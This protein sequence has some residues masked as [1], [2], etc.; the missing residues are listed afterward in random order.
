MNTVAPR[1]LTLHRLERALKERVRYRFVQPTVWID[2]QGYRVESPCCSRN[3]DPSGGTIAIA[4]L[5][6]PAA[7]AQATA[8]GWTLCARDHHNE[9]WVQHSH[10]DQIEPLL[11]LL[12]VD[13]E[14]RFWP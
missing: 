13:S 6:P 3:V 9:A 14:R 2:E 12:C 11:D 5:V 7:D 8:R 10:A 4:L 1:D